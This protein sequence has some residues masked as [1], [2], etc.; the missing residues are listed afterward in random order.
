MNTAAPFQR[1]FLTALTTATKGVYVDA[2]PIPDFLATM[3]AQLQQ[4]LAGRET[5]QTL[6]NTLQ[7]VYASHGRTAQF[8]DTD[9]EF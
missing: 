6:V 2:V 8:T 1:D 4:L 3:E 7:S 9:G 5:P